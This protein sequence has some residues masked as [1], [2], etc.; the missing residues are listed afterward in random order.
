MENSKFE[1]DDNTS[2]GDTCKETGTY[3]CNMHPYVEEY[4]IEGSTF[5][6]CG[7]KGMPHKTKWHLIQNEPTHKKF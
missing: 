7:Q 2:T 3:I 6:K 5:P 4:V 1:V